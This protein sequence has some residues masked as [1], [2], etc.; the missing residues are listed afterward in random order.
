[1]LSQL[2]DGIREI[3][4][5]ASSTG[6]GT[7]QGEAAKTISIGSG[8]SERVMQWNPETGRYDIPVGGGGGGS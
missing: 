6:Y 2:P 3:V 8:K 1:M 5:A 4:K 7:K